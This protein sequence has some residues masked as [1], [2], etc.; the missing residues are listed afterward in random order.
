[1]RKGKAIQKVNGRDEEGLTAAERVFV[2]VF[3]STGYVEKA[4]KQSGLP[5]V[6]FRRLIERGA[7][8]H[9]VILEAEARVY[10]HK[11]VADQVLL[12]LCK[13]KETPPNT[14]LAAA[15]ALRG[16]WLS[17]TEKNLNLAHLG[18]SGMSGR[19]LAEHSIEELRA[20][21]SNL[22]TNRA[23]VAR[24]VL[25]PIDSVIAESGAN[26]APTTIDPDDLIG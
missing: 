12:D 25:V 10:A 19:T 5:V 23:A 9:A 13:D 8:R 11:F 22:E 21:V 4:F 16:P 7:I 1:M 20:L 14:R 17:R 26:S 6:P 15:V 18:I 3:V 24:P 2:R